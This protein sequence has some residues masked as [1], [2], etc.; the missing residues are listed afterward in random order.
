MKKDYRITTCINFLLLTFQWPLFRH[1]FSAGDGIVLV[2]D[3]VD[4]ERLWWVKDALWRMVEEVCLQGTP[5]LV[6][7][8]KQDLPEA[9]HPD[10]IKKALRL[11]SVTTLNWRKAFITLNSLSYIYNTCIWDIHCKYVLNIAWLFIIY[12]F[13]VIYIAHFP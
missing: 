7:A 2:V 13:T 12:L 8:N 9:L 10:D 4:V 5:L 11:E 6:F 3:S 1:F